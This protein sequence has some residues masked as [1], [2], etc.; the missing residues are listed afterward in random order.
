MIPPVSQIDPKLDE[1][2]SRLFN[3]STETL[4]RPRSSKHVRLSSAKRV[5]TG[6]RLSTPQ[7]RAIA[8][9]VRQITYC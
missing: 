4:P 1:W 7:A 2:G 3:V 6:G 5:S 8:I 9:Y